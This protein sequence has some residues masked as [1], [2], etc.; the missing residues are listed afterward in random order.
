MSHPEDKVPEH[1]AD[2]A[3]RGNGDAPETRETDVELTVEAQP[4]DLQS[5]LDQQV[6]ETQKFQDLY[7]R[8]RADLENFKRRM[9]R[10]KSEAL[11]FANEPLVRDLLPVV[12][13][14]ERAIDHAVD[15]QSS[16]VEGVKLVFKAFLDVLARHGVKRIDTVDQTF[17]P[18]QHQAIA[19]VDSP[20]HAP[21]QVVA[22]HQPGYLLHDRLLRPAMVSVCG[23]KSSDGVE[24]ESNRD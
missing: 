9:Q 2:D 20:D 19:Q 3:K 10:E 21:N 7:T 13:N 5:R 23:P 24:S 17:D 6:S 16:V 12:D 4:Q 8:E 15:T 18:S 11:R 14:L 1:P 22:Q